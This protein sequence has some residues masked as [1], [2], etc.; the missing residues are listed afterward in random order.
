MLH[1]ALRAA[2]KED[3]S[4]MLIKTFLRLRGF[5]A[6][7]A[8]FR[9]SL[10]LEAFCAQRRSISG[11]TQ[12]PTLFCSQIVAALPQGLR[13]LASPI[14]ESSFSSPP[15]SETSEL[16]DKSTAPRSPRARPAASAGSAWLIVYRSAGSLAPV[17]RE[18]LAAGRRPDAETV[19]PVNISL[20]IY[21]QKQEM[22]SGRKPYNRTCV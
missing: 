21:M 22:L 3:A 12:K 19:G 9:R 13:S 20:L 17:C 4:G 5:S 18:M 8:T 2:E 14:C 10:I 6:T 1:R 7:S 11:K 15:A 16:L